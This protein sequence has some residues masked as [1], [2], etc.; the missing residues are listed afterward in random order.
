M[1]LVAIIIVVERSSAHAELV[2]G[3]IIFWVAICAIDPHDPVEWTTTTVKVFRCPS[4][5]G[6][7]RHRKINH[8]P[9]SEVKEKRP[10]GGVERGSQW[11]GFFLSS[12]SI[13]SPHLMCGEVS[14]ALVDGFC[15][16][17][18][19]SKNCTALEECDLVDDWKIEH[20]LRCWSFYFYIFFNSNFDV[21]YFFALKRDSKWKLSCTRSI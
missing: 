16:F 18:F 14:L 11:I 9:M 2:F 21:D 20:R 1:F 3:K 10:G 12:D 17:F 4:S 13:F 6:A 15:S 8:R 5:T 7:S 19:F